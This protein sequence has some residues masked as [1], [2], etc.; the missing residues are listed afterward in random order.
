MDTGYSAAGMTPVFAVEFDPA[1]CEVYR[2]NH[3]GHHI[4]CDTVENVAAH[5]ALCPDRFN[6]YHASPSCKKASRANATGGGESYSDQT[7]AESICTNLRHFTPEVFSLEN[8]RGYVTFAAFK[9]ILATLKNLNYRVQ[10]HIINAADYGVPQTRERLML[11]ATRHDMPLFEWPTPTHHNG[12]EYSHSDIWGKTKSRKRWISWH[13]A[14]E[15]L[16]P[17]LADSK[18]ADWQLRRL[19]ELMSST[20]VS[21]GS[22]HFDSDV[23]QVA[24]REL[25]APALTVTTSSH[26]RV[27]VFIIPGDNTSNGNVRMADEPSVTARS[28]ILEKGTAR[29]FL[30]DGQTNGNGNFVTKRYENEPPITIKACQTHQPLRAWLSHGRVVK[31][32]VLAL[33]R[34]QMNH[35]ADSYRFSGNTKLDSEVVGNGVPVELARAFGEKIVKLFE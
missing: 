3:S 35:Y 5:P 26:N 25:T 13:A 8:V 4:I 20:L 11:V 30:L 17:G 32:N 33:A 29:A 31:M 18:F 1:K 22:S 23:K 9:L 2:A 24:H 14:I 15:D 27:R 28:R 10:Y 21:A 7:A 6:V 12:P 34:F 19:P 16:L